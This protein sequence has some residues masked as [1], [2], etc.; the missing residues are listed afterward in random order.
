MDYQKIYNSMI[1]FR[2]K[3]IPE[4]YSEKHHIVPKCQGGNDKKSNLVRL[5][6]KEHF[7][8]HHLLVKIYKN[9]QSEYNLSCALHRMA[10]SNGDNMERKFTATM[11]ET[12]RKIQANLVSKK[13]Q[14]KG[15]PFFGKHHSKK[16]KQMISKANFAKNNPM[17]GKRKADHPAF[18]RKHSKEELE[19][20]SSSQRG[21]IFSDETK[22]KMSI[23]AKKREPNSSNEWIIIDQNG[24]RFEIKN[25]SKFCEKHEI[26]AYVR[27]KFYD[28]AKGRI[29]S[30]KGWICKYKNQPL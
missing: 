6:A 9:T 22:K 14:G 15:N 27:R 23:A 24:K 13:H 5:T 20:M 18:G 25:L 12:A 26:S 8:A 17:F 21:R 30:Y 29:K 10:F 19:K 7:V 4:G 11:F 16:S 2:A 28:I 3:N 1:D